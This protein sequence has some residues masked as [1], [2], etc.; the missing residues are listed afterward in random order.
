VNKINPSSRVYKF[1]VN[2]LIVNKEYVPA[3]M[4]LVFRLQLDVKDNETACQNC[5]GMGLRQNHSMPWCEYVPTFLFCSS[6]VGAVRMSSRPKGRKRGKRRIKP[7]LVE[8]SSVYFS[9][10]E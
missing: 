10:R 6:P 8:D 9:F 2:G 1:F 3:V 4:I 7:T 5:R